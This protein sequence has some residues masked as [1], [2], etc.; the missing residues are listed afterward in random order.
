MSLDP[1]NEPG[2]AAPGKQIMGAQWMKIVGAGFALLTLLV[3]LGLGV[4]SSVGLAA[5][6][7]SAFS[8]LAAAFAIGSAMS[9]IFLGGGAAVGGNLGE[10]W[11]ARPLRISLGGGA[12]M[13]VI[14]FGIFMMLK[15][16]NCG[17][18]GTNA[19]LQ[20]QFENIPN[21]ISPKAGRDFW[22]KVDQSADGNYRIVSLLLDGKVDMGRLSMSNNSDMACFITV[23][24]VNTLPTEDAERFHYFSLDPDTP[25]KFHYSLPDAV[26]ARTVANDCFRRNGRIVSKALEIGLTDK[27]VRFARLDQPLGPDDAFDESYLNLGATS[28]RRADAPS[29]SLISAAFAFTKGAS[30]YQELSEALASTNDVLR[31][32]A[33]QYLGENFE[34]YSTEAVSDLVSF[35]DKT[36]PELLSSLLHG[37]IVGMQLKNPN[38]KPRSGRS[39]VQPLPYLEGNEALILTLSGH[40]HEWVRKQARRLMQ[41]YPVDAF[42]PGFEALQTRLTDGCTGPEDGWRIY[43][44]AFFYYNRIVQIGLNTDVGVSEKEKIDQAVAR[45]KTIGRGCV[46]DDADVDLALLDYGRALA[47]SWSK[48]LDPGASVDAAQDFRSWIEGREPQYYRQAHVARMAVK[49]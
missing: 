11:Q 49:P 30:T 3:F 40:P 16:E 14:M 20:L 32:E 27:Q 15:P 46:P 18:S 12:A 7:C 37:V 21:E 36:S 39:L 33:R 13:L 10:F 6:N 42:L 23:S 38:L 17:A 24:V 41:R 28:T 5:F 26:A 9:A 25:L 4:A 2:G 31:I 1:E 29:F 8:F 22:S 43:A 44:A 19:G 47:Y 48:T 35:T 45:L 34:K